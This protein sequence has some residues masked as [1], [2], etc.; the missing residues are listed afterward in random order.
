[1]GVQR[2]G[3]KDTECAKAMRV[4]FCR[5]TESRPRGSVKG[6]FYPRNVKVCKAMRF[7]LR[8]NYVLSP[9]LLINSLS[10]SLSLLSNFW[11][12][13]GCLGSLCLCCW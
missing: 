4:C 9:S 3:A 11:G 12:K 6:D 13:R 8:N 1:M 10:F 7:R 2:C 5:N